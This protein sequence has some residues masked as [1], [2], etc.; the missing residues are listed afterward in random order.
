MWWKILIFLAVIAISSG[1]AGAD[2]PSA[3]QNG[4]CI[5]T[6]ED[7]AVFAQQ[8]LQK[9]VIR[10]SDLKRNHIAAMESEMSTA[11]IDASN[12][13]EFMPG[14]YFVYKTDENRF[15]KF[16]VE[17]YEPDGSYDM[18][19]KWVT[20]DTDG[21]IYSFGTRLI[22][23]STWSCDLDEGLETTIGQDWNWM[24]LSATER[25]LK[26]YNGAK[27]K[28]M[29]RAKAPDGMVWIY[30]DDPGVS[31]YEGYMS[32]YETTNAQYCEYLNVAL[33]EEKIKVYNNI[34]YATSDISHSERYFKTYA[35][36]PSSQIIYTAGVFSVRTRDG[37]DMSNHPVLE[38]SWY[39][40]TA[41]CDYYGY[42]LPTEWEWQAVADYDGSYN[43]GC[44]IYIDHDK[45]NYGYYN[46]L[47][48]SRSPYTTPVDYYPSFGYGMNDMT[49]NVQ[50]LT[51]SCF[52]GE[53]ETGYRVVRGGDWHEYGPAILNVV[54]RRGYPL[55]ALDEI[56]GFRPVLIL[57]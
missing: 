22:I 14:T 26:T 2:C 21:S 53:C 28:L 17:N 36:S 6:F 29:N 13:N 20:Y 54:D 56:T 9:G 8:W 57:D 52:F 51:D 31:G 7:F 48:L 4:D 40:A 16:M 27:F 1:S 12:G 30:A 42:R 37:Y 19:I 24:L 50:E 55:W 34:V 38:V 49:G 32:K 15:G 5:V 25:R 47:G 23:R 3:D 41:F 43:Y 10:Y 35:A 46:P 39:G 44:G 18:V 11:S 45:A 33:A